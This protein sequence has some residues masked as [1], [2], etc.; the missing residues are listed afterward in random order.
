MKETAIDGYAGKLI[1]KQCPFSEHKV[2]SEDL[3]IFET[4]GTPNNRNQKSLKAQRNKKEKEE[5]K[6]I[7]LSKY[8]ENPDPAEM[9]SP[10]K[11]KYK[12]ILFARSDI[13]L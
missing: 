10:E 1:R 12:E 5:P 11:R 6:E 9:T 7:D 2:N 4:M 13:V 8:G 3:K